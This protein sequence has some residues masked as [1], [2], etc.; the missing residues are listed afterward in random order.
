M[1]QN[2]IGAD[3]IAIDILEEE[4]GDLHIVEYNDIPGLSGF[5]DEL[6]YELATVL[7]RALR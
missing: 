6:K 4:N 7:T 2:A 5:S 1:L 3:I